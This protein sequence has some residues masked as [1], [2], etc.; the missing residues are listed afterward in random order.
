LPGGHLP[1]DTFAW[2]TFAWKTFAWTTLALPGKCLAGKCHPGKCIF[3]Q[4]SSWKMYPRTYVIRTNVFGFLHDPADPAENPEFH[5]AKNI[6]TKECSGKKSFV[7]NVPAKN[8]PANK[9]WPK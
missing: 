6:P 8:A 7:K 2:K 3:G 5:Y 4:M 9:F 1:A